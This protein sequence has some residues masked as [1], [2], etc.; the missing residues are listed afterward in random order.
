MRQLN[1]KWDTEQGRGKDLSA[2]ATYISSNIS[3]YMPQTY[4]Q[5]PTATAREYILTVPDTQML[6]SQAS[7]AIQP[8]QG[9]SQGQQLR[10]QE[11]SYLVVYGQQPGIQ[12]SNISSSAQPRTVISNRLLQLPYKRCFSGS[13]LTKLLSK[14]LLI[15]KV[16]LRTIQ[17]SQK[18]LLIISRMFKKNPLHCPTQNT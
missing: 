6:H 11:T 7:Q 14:P 1:F 5:Q 2:T 15:Q 10:G 18:Q 3:T 4:N 8:G 13:F 16:L 17:I 9:M 12:E